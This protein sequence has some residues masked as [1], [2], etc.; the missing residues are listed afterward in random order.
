MIII[1][2]WIMVVGVA[3][4]AI[5]EVFALIHRMMM[6]REYNRRNAFRHFM[7]ATLNTMMDAINELNDNYKCCIEDIQSEEKHEEPL[8][9]GD[10]D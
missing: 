9:F 2:Y 1:G 10:E 5:V 4:I 3:V 7:Y 6:R 8:K